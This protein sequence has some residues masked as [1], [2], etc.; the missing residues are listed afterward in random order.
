[1]TTV[2]LF[3]RLEAKSG[4]ESEVADFLKSGLAIVEDEPATT[5][6]FAL[7]LGPST[8]GIFDALPLPYELILNNTS[9]APWRSTLAT[10]G[11]A[12]L[13]S[14]PSMAAGSAGAEGG[15]GFEFGFGDGTHGTSALLRYEV[16]S[17]DVSVNNRRGSTAQAPSR[18]GITAPTSSSRRSETGS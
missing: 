7:Q 3:V 17:I 14:P 9:S 18:S 10:L 4:K 16:K 8:F 1:M 5:A 12:V 6:W 13:S 15:R 11:S 2:A